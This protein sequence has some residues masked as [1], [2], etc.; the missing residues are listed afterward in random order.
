MHSP[1]IM[2]S[3]IEVRSILT[4]LSKKVNVIM[5]NWVAVASDKSIPSVLS[6]QISSCFRW[7]LTTLI[8]VNPTIRL[9][10]IVTLA[11]LLIRTYIVVAEG[12]EVL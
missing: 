10:Y 2:Y 12:I 1:Q 11:S 9:S 3:F 5:Y 4:F 7:A 6:L 8:L